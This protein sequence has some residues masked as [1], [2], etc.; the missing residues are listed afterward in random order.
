VLRRVFG[1][2]RDELTGSA[3]GY[4]TRR[5]MVCTPPQIFSG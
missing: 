4:I 1:P 5:R 3:E 2:E